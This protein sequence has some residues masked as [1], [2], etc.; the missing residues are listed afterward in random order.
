MARYLVTGGCG[1]I[2]S[3]LV[4]QL[5]SDGHEVRVLDDLSSGDR[6]RVPATAEF[7]EGSILDPDTIRGALAGINGV[8]HLAAVASVVRSTKALTSSHLANVAG[9]VML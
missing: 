6:Q 8:F 2:G 1:F 4:E 3:H 9:F 7:V 5:L